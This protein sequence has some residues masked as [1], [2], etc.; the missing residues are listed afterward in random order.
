MLAIS[1]AIAVIIF[2]GTTVLAEWIVRLPSSN[3]CLHIAKW[4]EPTEKLNCQPCLART[5]V[6]GPMYDMSHEYG[7][8]Y[9]GSL[10]QGY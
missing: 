10:L 3:P 8:D 9:M 6:R 7:R 5:T 4:Y 2:R 1:V